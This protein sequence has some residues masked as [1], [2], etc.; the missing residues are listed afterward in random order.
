MTDTETGKD[1][2]PHIPHYIANAPWYLGAEGPTLK[3]QRPHP[4]RQIELAEITDV[5]RRGMYQHKEN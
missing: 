3:H 1:I 2:N 4:E 5:Y